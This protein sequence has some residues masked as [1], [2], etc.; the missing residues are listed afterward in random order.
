MDQ[1]AKRNFA[2]RRTVFGLLA[3]TVISRAGS[4]A[5]A[6]SPVSEQSQGWAHVDCD[7]EHSGALQRAI[8]RATSGQTIL[9]D[10]TCN[11]SVSIP[12]GK[13]RIT[14]DGGGGG[15]IHGPDVTVN[16]LLIRGPRA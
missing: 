8:D 6:Q 16:V 1:R 2:V 10:G 15:A 4:I 11:E 7:K 14:L 3:L 13:D 9:I 5:T 12:P